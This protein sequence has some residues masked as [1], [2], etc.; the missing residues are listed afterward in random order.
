M[1]E[2]VTT[3][4]SLFQKAAAQPQRGFLVE[5]DV[6]DVRE[7]RPDWDER[8]AIAFLTQHSQEIADQ[9]PE[10]GITAVIALANGSEHA[11]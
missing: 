10:A 2:Q 11:N 6:S 1:S 4:A 5:I 9:M 7:V 3:K 8:Q